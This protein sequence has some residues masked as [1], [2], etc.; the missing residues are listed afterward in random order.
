M[1]LKQCSQGHFYDEDRFGN[2]CPFCQS[3]LQDILADNEKTIPQGGICENVT[4]TQ[5]LTERQEVIPLEKDEVTVGIVNTNPDSGE[6]PVVGWLVCVE[7]NNYG[8]DFRLHAGR[9]FVGRS[10]SMD[11]CLEGDSSV[12]RF[13]HAVIVY[14]P[15]SG[16]Y[17]A[18]PGESRELFYV[19]NEVVLESI[20]LHAYDLLEVGNSRLLFVPFCGEQFAW[21]NMSNER[22][23]GGKTQE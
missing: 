22:K 15:K 4:T 9:N 13:S 19:N 7:G 5:A 8:R 18:Q 23:E 17:L 10:R 14:D 16:T 11:I 12:S 20:P 1:K 6:E 3:G 21:T 2:V